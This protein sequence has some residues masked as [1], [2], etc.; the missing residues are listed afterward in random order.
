M[1]A[2]RVAALAVVAVNPPVTDGVT[3]ANVQSVHD[4]LSLCRF[5]LIDP[6]P[7]G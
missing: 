6:T 2:P 7:T 3:R 1:N 4:A 5:D